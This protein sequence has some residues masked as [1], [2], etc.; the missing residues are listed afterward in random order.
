MR[1][2]DRKNLPPGSFT[3]TGSSRTSKTE[4][5]VREFVK[6]CGYKI[7]DQGTGLIVHGREAKGRRRQLTPD[8]IVYGPGKKRLIVEVD[9]YFTHAQGGLSSVYDDM[10]RNVE[11]ARLGYSVVRLRIGFD[12]T[13]AEG[14]A[15]LSPY[16][17][18]VTQTEFNNGT[19]KR[20]LRGAMKKARPVSPNTWN[21]DLNHLRAYH[22]YDKRAG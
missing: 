8:I 17:V 15:R 13:P 22:I 18:V 11:Y 4:L 1:H 16:D 19:Y 21:K 12:N 20:F 3:V 7:M 14:F 10:D 5:S 2:P 9:P 6:R